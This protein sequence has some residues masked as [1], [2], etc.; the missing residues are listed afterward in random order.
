MPHRQVGWDYYG[1]DFASRDVWLKIKSEFDTGAAPE[2]VARDI[3]MPPPPALR[4]R[5][6]A[7]PAQDED[8]QIVD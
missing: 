8:A 5:Q 2:S 7:Q 6:D 4:A 1:T 3:D